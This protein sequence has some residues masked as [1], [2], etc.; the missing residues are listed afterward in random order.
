MGSI[1]LVNLVSRNCHRESNKRQTQQ[2]PQREAQLTSPKPDIH[3]QIASCLT[4]ASSLRG[5]LLV[6]VLPLGPAD[7]ADPPAL[8][9]SL[10]GAVVTSDSTIWPFPYCWLS[11]KAR[12]GTKGTRVSVL[13]G[14]SYGG[15]SE[16]PI[17]CAGAC[18][19][20]E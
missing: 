17:G 10:P 19:L 5:E 8:D 12:G 6:L 14:L 11:V 18:L 2:P 13:R 15:G 16:L 4:M 3:H 9:P 20:W 1:R 7:P